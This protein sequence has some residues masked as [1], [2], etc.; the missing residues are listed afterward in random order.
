MKPQF[1]FPVTMCCGDT[2][3]DNS[4]KESWAE[5]YAENRLR[6]IL[7]RAEAKNGEDADFQESGRGHDRR[8]WCC[9][10]SETTIS[11]AA[12]ALAR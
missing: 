5:F 3:Q 1:G 6:F 11:M 10:L 12:S 7:R 2:P 4:Y 8:R 9:G